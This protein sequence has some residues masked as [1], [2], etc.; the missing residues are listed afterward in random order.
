MGTVPIGETSNVFI[1]NGDL[2]SISAPIQTKLND[3][4]QRRKPRRHCD[5]D[6]L[7]CI[8]CY[9]RLHRELRKPQAICYFTH[10][11]L[12][13]NCRVTTGFH[14][15]KYIIAGRL[16]FRGLTHHRVTHGGVTTPH[17]M[18]SAVAQL[19]GENTKHATGQTCGERGSWNSPSPKWTGRSSR[20]MGTPLISLFVEQKAT[21]LSGVFNRK[22]PMCYPLFEASNRE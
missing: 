2:S 19:A 6:F 7:Q 18:R 20:L 15:D 13:R 9:H 10:E 12:K 17:T 1:N 21:Y 3:V 4:V 5:E 11:K 14:V 8:H 22:N 16:A